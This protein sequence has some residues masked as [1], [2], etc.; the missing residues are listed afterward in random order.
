M[1]IET[2]KEIG[3]SEWKKDKFHR[4]YFNELHTWYGLE[5]SFYK[6]G[7]ISSASLNGA[8]IS[9]SQA[10]SILGRISGKLWLDLIDGRWHWLNLS[11]RDALVLIKAIEA[12]AVE[13]ENPKPAAKAT[14]AGIMKRAWQIAREG[15]KSFG[16]SSKDYLAEALRIAWSESRMEMAA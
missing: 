1:K 5:C 16:G 9:N 8:K 7:N 4:I 15:A 3:G 6:T 14:K 13:T 2:L 12:K 11:D 10:N